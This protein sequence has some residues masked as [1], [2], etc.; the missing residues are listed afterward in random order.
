MIGPHRL[1]LDYLVLPR[2]VRWAGWLV[3]AAAIGAGALLAEA[4]RDAQLELARLETAAGLVG[5]ERRPVPAVPAAR[6]DEE[7]KSAEAVVRE[8]TLPWAA[9]IRALEE[10]ATRDVAILQL[11]PDAQSRVL[12]LTAEA[13]SREAMFA[14]LRRLS[15]S[16]VLVDTHMVSH[17]LRH[18]DPQRPIQFSVEAALR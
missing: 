9:V 18:D 13:H 2:R 16:K 12:K 1:E 4:W 17:Q 6:L 15:A 10:A 14:Y 5:S 7:T 8:L 3:L 11:Q